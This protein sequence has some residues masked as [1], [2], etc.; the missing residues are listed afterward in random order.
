[1]RTEKSALT[2]GC[3]SIGLQAAKRVGRGRALRMMCAA[4]HVACAL[5]VAAQDVRHPRAEH[6]IRAESLVAEIAF[7]P[8]SPIPGT[9]ANVQKRIGQLGTMQHEVVIGRRG[10]GEDHQFAF[11]ADVEV[12]AQG[13]SYVLDDRLNALRVFSPTGAFRYQLGRSGRGPGEYVEP[14]AFAL[15]ARGDVLVGDLTRRLHVY[16]RTP[17]GHTEGTSHTD[18]SQG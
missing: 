6:I 14:R 16:R 5:V 11:I 15:S 12:D 18:E 13:N 1:M 8:H 9:F 7:T 10:A 4:Q 17:T 3:V 2:I